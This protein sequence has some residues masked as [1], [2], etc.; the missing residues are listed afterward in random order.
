MEE[1]IAKEKQ[2]ASKVQVLEELQREA[3]EIVEDQH[4]RLE[5]ARLNLTTPLASDTEASEAKN[6]GRAR[7]K[8]ITRAKLTL[9]VPS[10]VSQEAMAST[11]SDHS[12]LWLQQPPED[13]AALLR[14]EVLNVSLGTVNMQ[15]G[16]A[17]QSNEMKNKL[18]GISVKIK[19]S[20]AAIYLKYQIWP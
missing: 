17:P 7:P 10:T 16:T 2:N 8:T 14:N 13:H 12:R 20:K 4:C 19:C 11:Y 3:M 1:L 5:E 18:A 6:Y 15:H 9:L